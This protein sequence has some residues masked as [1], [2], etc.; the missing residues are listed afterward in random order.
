MP[1]Y[2]ITLLGDAAV[3]KT[4][5]RKKFMGEG[6]KSNYGMT[7]GADFA[8]YKMDDYTLHIWDLAGQIQYS[9]MISMYF[10]GTLGSLLVFDVSRKDSFSNLPRW[11]NELIKNNENQLV[12]L[13]VV[14]NKTDLRNATWDA[15]QPNEGIEYANSLSEWANFEIPYI[16]TSA[17]TGLNV[18]LIFKKLVEKIDQQLIV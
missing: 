14:G 1:V 4:S 3:G 6:L 16:E 8:V 15:L 18:D 11:I 2:K 10:R 9:T 7:I 12:P 13:V 17:L 5:L